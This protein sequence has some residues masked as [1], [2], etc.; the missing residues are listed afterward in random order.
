MLNRLLEEKQP[1][2][3]SASWVY[4]NCPAVYRFI[5]KNVRTDYGVDWDRV[6]SALP[7]KFQKRWHS[8]RKV[9]AKPYRN[10]AEVR[11]VLRKHKA[12][13]YTFVSASDWDDKLKRDLISV[14]LVRLAQN[15]NVRAK[16]ELMKLLG[17]TIEG[18]IELSPRISRWQW[19]SDQIPEQID[20]CIRCY[21][22]TGSFMRYLFRTLELAGRRLQSF[23][24]SS[25]D[26][27]YLNTEK[28]K[29]DNV[30]RDPETQEIRMH[31]R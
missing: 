21:R 14:A 17:Y 20:R 7:R 9:Y 3:F 25:L 15:G 5:W 30:V 27:C 2:S 8:K 31:S 29:I 22:Y 19:Y 10:M 18:W 12:T 1:E 16:Q 24:T 11:K 4:F 6:T 28:M 26:E 13:L 23:F